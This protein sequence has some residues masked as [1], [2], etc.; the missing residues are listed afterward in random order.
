[1]SKEELFRQNVGSDV[2]MFVD[3]D[4]WKYLHYFIFGAKLPPKVQQQFLERSKVAFNE[5]DALVRL[6][7]QQARS[8]TID[9]ACRA[10]EFYK[11]ALDCDCAVRDALNIRRAIL[12]VRS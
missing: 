1:M 11:L 5:W 9:R 12:T 2:E 10:D 3:S 6:A 7:R 4:F 8:L